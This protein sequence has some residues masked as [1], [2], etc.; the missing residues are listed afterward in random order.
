MSERTAFVTFHGIDGTGKTTAAEKLTGLLSARGHDVV[1]YD[2]IPSDNPFSIAKRGVI[3]ETSPAAQ[4]AFFIGS[5]LY[6]SERIAEYLRAGKSV[7]K[8]RYIDDVIAHH[9]HLG[10]ND[11]QRITNSFNILQPHLRVLLTLD[12]EERRRRIEARG[13]LDDKDREQFVEG[14]RLYAFQN[15]L[16]RIAGELVVSGRALIIDT[17]TNSPNDVSE[18]VYRHL[19]AGNLI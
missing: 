19:Q 17:Q 9:E 10:V 7:V 3:A 13:I 16:I 2:L 15:T 14:S 6:H 8:A 1:N 12:E 5:T 11:I 4:A 18:I